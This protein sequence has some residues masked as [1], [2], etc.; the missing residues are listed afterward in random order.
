VAKEF[1]YGGDARLRML[2][3]VN[4]IAGAVQITLGPQGRNVLIQHRTE[5]I[6]PVF[7]RDGVTVVRS[8]NTD[9]KVRDVGVSMLRQMAGRV[10]AQAGD[11]T[12]TAIVLARR[13]AAEAVRTM[14]AGVDPKCMR[15]GIELAVRTAVHD[16][17][18]R[19]KPCGERTAIAHIGTQAANGDRGIGEMLAEAFERVGAEGVISV[20]LGDGFDDKIEYIEGTRWEQGYVSRYFVTDKDRE[21]A[22]LE[23]PYVLMYD[24]VIHKFDELVRILEMVRRKGGSLLIVAENIEE[25]ALPGILLNHIRCVLKAVVVKP[26]AYGDKRADALG[27]L[28]VLLGGRA[29]LE[30]CGDDLAR[31]K[32]EDLG[33]AKRVIIGEDTTTVIGGAG[34]AEAIKLRIAH[35]QQQID[36][37]D[38]QAGKG[39]A[40]GKAHDREQLEER[41]TRLSGGAAVVRVGGG[42]DVIIKERIQRFNNAINSIRGA[43]S[44]GVLPG[45]GAALLRAQKALDDLPRQDFDTQC[46]INIVRKAIGEPVRL[47]AS[48]AGE[49]P[50]ETSERIRASDDPFFGLDARQGRFGNLYELGVLDSLKVA[51]T[52]L[53][54]AA[55]VASSLMTT[56]CV[57]S[58]I[59]PKDPTYGF[60]PEWAEATREDPR[61]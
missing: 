8:I 27:D 11:G 39:S 10:S 55:G 21:I 37:I 56:E 46:G 30:S 59:P 3:G 53:Q 44:E 35:V 34:D 47:I 20:E 38:A 41:I 60:T 50:G 26:P 13:I 14:N 2:S 40:A 12:S 1:H 49:D 54:E 5:G 29:I 33:R 15:E 57:I 22:E 45:G 31:V 17:Q 7:T 61:S 18:Q 58:Q 4:L 9:D 24:R 43:M 19:A 6:L 36:W 52:T 48:N 32:L 42:S 25:A 16:L 51:R 28:A 23:D